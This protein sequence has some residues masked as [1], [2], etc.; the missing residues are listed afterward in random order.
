MEK[1]KLKFYIWLCKT[2]LKMAKKLEE[3][4]EKDPRV[5]IDFNLIWKKIK[6]KN[7]LEYFQE[8]LQKLEKA[9]K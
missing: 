9:E 2:Y 8:E 3:S 7:Y 1:F 6:Y 4:Y 5:I